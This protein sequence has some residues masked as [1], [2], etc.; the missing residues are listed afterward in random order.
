MKYLIMICSNPR[1]WSHPIFLESDEAAA[2]SQEERDRMVAD[3]EAMFA[4]IAASGELVSGEALADPS[5][6]M[7]LR[8]HNGVPVTTDGPFGEAKEQ[9]AGH[10]TS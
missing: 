2:L 4:E 8:V 7:T 5:Q 6:T 10:W 1:S 9:M 3:E